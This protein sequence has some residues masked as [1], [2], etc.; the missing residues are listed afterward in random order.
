MSVSVISPVPGSCNLRIGE[1]SRLFLVSSDGLLSDNRRVV[2]RKEESVFRWRLS[3]E[4]IYRDGGSRRQ[5]ERLRGSDLFLRTDLH[6]VERT[7]VRKII[8]WDILPEDPVF[9]GAIDVPEDGEV[10]V[11][12]RVQF[13]M[14]ERPRNFYSFGWSAA[15][16]TSSQYLHISTLTS[17]FTAWINESRDG[18]STPEIIDP[19]KSSISVSVKRSLG[20]HS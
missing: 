8:V 13:I 6:K 1:R 12:Y 19:S 3:W 4:L 7:G 14:P 20:K 11:L 15:A 2:V 9:V 16:G 17:P 10:E 18:S 5:Y